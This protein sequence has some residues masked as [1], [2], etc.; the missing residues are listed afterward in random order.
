MLITKC[1]SELKMKLVIQDIARLRD[2][3][4]YKKNCYEILSLQ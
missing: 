4:V 2:N 3:Q 1:K